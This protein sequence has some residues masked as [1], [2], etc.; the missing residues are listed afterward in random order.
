MKVPMRAALILLALAAHSEASAGGLFPGDRG[1]RPL[2]RGFAFV[3]GA[4]DPQALWYNP[5]GIAWSGQQLLLDISLPV[6][7]HSFTRIDSGGNTLPTVDANAPTLP[8]PALAYTHPI[9]SFTLGFGIFAPTASPY[10][11]PRGLRADGSECNYADDSLEDPQCTP[12]PQRYSLYSLE[13]TALI[14]AI[15]A[16]SWRPV[17]SFAIGLG[18]P[19]M[20]GTF[21]GESA[22]SAC[23][24]FLCGQAENPEWDGLARFTVSPVLHVGVSGG[25]TFDAGII[26][27]GASFTW[28]PNAIRGRATLESRL[29][30]AALFDGARVEGDAAEFV[31]PYPA[32]LRGGAELRPLDELRVEASVV[33][34]RWSTQESMRIIPDN[35]WIRDAIAIGDYQLGEISIPRNMRDVF[36]V[37][38]GGTYE[39]IPKRLQVSLG[40]AYESSGF[41]DSTLTPL[42]LDTDKVIAGLGVSVGL[43][44]G[45]WLDI[46]YGHFFMRERSVRNSEVAQPTPLRPARRDG[47]PTSEG[48]AA[49]IGNGDYT[50]EMDVFGLGLRW[51]FDAGTTSAATPEAAD[52]AEETPPA[53]RPLS[54]EQQEEEGASPQ[55]FERGNSVVEPSREANPMSETES[56]EV[57]DQAE[58]ESAD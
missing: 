8:I 20:V 18:V 55:W 37:R 49:Y 30:S 7:R 27:L 38:V 15:P 35:V 41:G 52:D 54:E 16:I 4:D 22:I 14:Q 39:A 58:L 50:M 21:V 6:M 19:I 1:I 17:E 2:G 47:V 23:E 32:I 25:L 3:A 51:Q 53:E 33:Y 36:S 11:F 10:G 31:F 44:E 12:A 43:T 40:V 29:P 48:G 42:T 56:T 24:G 26:R 5:A 46:A 28:F 34:E 13:G 45:L 57:N 9:G